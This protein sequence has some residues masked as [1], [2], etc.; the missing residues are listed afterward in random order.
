MFAMVF[1][2]SGIFENPN[3]TFTQNVHFSKMLQIKLEKKANIAAVSSLYN[4]NILAK[5]DSY[6]TLYIT[7]KYR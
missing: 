5:S 6:I 7:F 4:L 2:I 3:I 1:I